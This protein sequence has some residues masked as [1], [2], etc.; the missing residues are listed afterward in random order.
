M[1]VEVW[2]S[3]LWEQYFVNLEDFVAGAAGQHIVSFEVQSS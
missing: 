2:I 3:L 1:N